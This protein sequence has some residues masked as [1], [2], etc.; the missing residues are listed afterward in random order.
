MR[1]LLLA[2]MLLLA[3]PAAYA[4]G[5]SGPGSPDDPESMVSRY[6]DVIFFGEV[7]AVGERQKDKYGS[8]QVIR[9]KPLNFIKGK[10]PREIEIWIG[11]GGN[12]CDLEHLEFQVG[13]RYLM[14]G[15]LYIGQQVDL[16]L[17]RYHNNFCSLHEQVDPNTL[18][19]LKKVPDVRPHPTW[20]HEH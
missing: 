9:F 18:K 4:C 11:E 1:N 16:K 6:A 8:H 2:M 10:Q 3:A 14:S 20:G 15:N 12:S 7:T 17:T 19:P 5:C 13:E